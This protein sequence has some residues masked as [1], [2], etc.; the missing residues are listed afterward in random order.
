M[1]LRKQVE[2]LLELRF[3]LPRTEAC[4]PHS[5]AIHLVGTLAQPRLQDHHEQSRDLIFKR[6][7]VPQGGEKQQRA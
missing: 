1:N 2:S 3:R 4:T 7:L 6:I 5:V